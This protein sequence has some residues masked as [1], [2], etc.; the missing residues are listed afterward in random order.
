MLDIIGV[1]P[2]QLI[3]GYATTH[4]LPMRHARLYWAVMLVICVGLLPIR[5]LIP[6]PLR[7]LCSVTTFALPAFLYEGP[8]GRRLLATASVVVCMMAVEVASDALWMVLTGTPIGDYDAA[9]ANMPE[10]LF[11]HLMCWVALIAVFSALKALFGKL[12]S[13]GSGEGML[14]YAGFPT[15]QSIFL[16]LMATIGLYPLREQHSWFT[17]AAVMSALCLAINLLLFFSMQRYQA[18]RLEDQRR[19][20]L[21]R[22]LDEYL[23]ESGRVVREIASV[24][25]LRHDL[26]NQVQ[27]ISALVERGDVDH[28]REL[29]DD[30]AKS[31]A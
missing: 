31:C 14:A 11:M 17:W 28:A 22:Q 23:S 30:L 10:F 27:V 5:G 26:R 9:R 18:K 24:S 6:A 13:S 2:T 3:L 29:V 1:A 16:M 19:E 12:N 7:I 20:A 21:E 25:Q 15:V 8:I 4:L